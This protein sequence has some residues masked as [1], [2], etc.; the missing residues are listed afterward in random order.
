MGALIAERSAGL[1][2][3]IAGHHGGIPNFS[4]LRD[5]LSEKRALLDDARRDGLPKD[6][7]G[8]ALPSPPTWVAADPCGRAMWVRFLFSALVDADFL[9][10]EHFY[11]GQ[12]R[13][14]GEPLPLATLRDKLDAHLDRISMGATDVN[15]MRARVLANCRSAADLAPGAFTLTV[16]TGGGKTL[17]SLSFAF[18][19][20]VKHGLRRVIVVIPYT[21]IIEQTTKTYRDVLG[22]DA[23]VEHHSN[24][25]PDKENH[26]NRLASENWTR[27]L[28]LPQVCSSSRACMQIVHQ[29]AASFTG[30]PRVL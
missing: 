8:M 13:D 5:R 12:L 17:A 29:G 9:D 25:D 11:Q 23:V 30:L 20:A 26:R 2:L 14:L 22:Q 24:L 3:V 15:A 16:P 1:A 10:T 19:H 28:W 27:R 18:R 4:A 7:E 6:L 21:S